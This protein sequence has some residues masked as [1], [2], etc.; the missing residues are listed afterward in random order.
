MFLSHIICF[1][2]EHI[3]MFNLSWINAPHQAKNHKSFRTNYVPIKD[4]DRR[5]ATEVGRHPG[6]NIDLN[7]QL[8]NIITPKKFYLHWRTL[9]Y[10]TLPKLD[11]KASGEILNC[12][13]GFTMRICS[14]R[15]AQP[16]NH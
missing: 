7:E 3:F 2:Y 5:A 13:L 15:P 6:H 10:N 16:Q 12:Q 4:Q 1:F 11:H 8:F 9:M 14:V